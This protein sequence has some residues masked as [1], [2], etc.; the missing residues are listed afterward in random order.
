[1]KY[2]KRYSEAL[3]QVD[4]E[5]NYSIEEAVG[6]LR[7]MPHVKFDET[8]EA[9]C[10]LGVDPQKSDQMVRG[11]VVLPNGSGKKIK[12]LVFCDPEKEKEAI[13]AGADY[14]GSQELA[15]KIEKEGWLEFDY[16]IS[17]PAMMRIVGKL[18]R[19]LG[20]RGLMP[21]PK[22]GTVTDNISYAVAEAKRGKVDFRMDK[23]GC[24]HL[25]LG[26]LSFSQ[27][28]LVENI[29]AF[30]NALNAARPAAA[31]GDFI[32][33]IYLSST[34]SPAIKVAV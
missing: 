9:S 32:K 13:A 7:N 20:P 8:L 10:N 12:I 27:Q 11:T 33:S 22:T 21:S 15:T 25:G 23:A 6:I 2:S 14:A 16:C 1:M 26:K 3:K 5:K 24:I 31:K 29:S 28:A 4:K 34:M 30:V 18:G 17:T 19:V